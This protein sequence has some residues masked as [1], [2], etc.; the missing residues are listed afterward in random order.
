MIIHAE[1]KIFC[2]LS[3]INRFIIYGIIYPQGDQLQ[4][5]KFFVPN[6]CSPSSFGQVE[7]CL[8]Q[9][10]KKQFIT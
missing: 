9:N 10:T 7:S 2:A 3:L 8:E 5:I 6:L 4:S 1:Q